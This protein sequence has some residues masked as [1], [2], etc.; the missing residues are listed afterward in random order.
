MLCIFQEQSGKLPDSFDIIIPEG[1]FPK[2]RFPKRF[3]HESV[4]HEL[5]VQVPYGCDELMGIELCVGFS[6]PKVSYIPL[7][8][9]FL[10]VGLKSMDLKVHHQYALLLGQT[11]IKLDH[12]TFGN[13]ICLLAISTPNGEKI[14][15]KLIG[16]DPIKLRLE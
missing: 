4:S 12:L 5:Q 6:V 9:F 16:M 11:I 14:F 7:K 8:I 15:V 3:E 10:H 1:H 2:G 13:S